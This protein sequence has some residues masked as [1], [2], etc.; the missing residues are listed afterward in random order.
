MNL[1]KYV[2]KGVN[3]DDEML[4]LKTSLIQRRAELTRQI[5]NRKTAIE[6]MRVNDEMEL[7]SVKMVAEQKLISV[8]SDPH[9]SYS[10][11]LAAYINHKNIS[12]VKKV[13]NP[14]IDLYKEEIK[15]LEQ[16]LEDFPTVEE[17]KEIKNKS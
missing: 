1:L 11:T 6:E 4:P 3:G 7:P 13:D 2:H 14:T 15:V 17:I 10:D 9:A 16:M 12:G 5:N 8:L